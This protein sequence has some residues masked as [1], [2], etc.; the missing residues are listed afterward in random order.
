[1]KKINS[2]LSSLLMLL[3]F[4]NCIPFTGQS[5]T[6]SATSGSINFENSNHLMNGIS[7]SQDVTGFLSV[8]IDRIGGQSEMGSLRMTSSSLRFSPWNFNT[9]AVR[10]WIGAG[11]CYSALTPGIALTSDLADKS[12]KSDLDLNKQTGITIPISAGLDLQ[13]SD[14]FNTSVSVS[15]H[16][17]KPSTFDDPQRA[18][19]AKAAST[20]AIITALQVGLAF[21]IITT[22]M[23]SRTELNYKYAEEMKD[24]INQE[25]PVL[26]VDTKGSVVSEEEWNNIFPALGDPDTYVIDHEV[27]VAQYSKADYKKMIKASEKKIEMYEKDAVESV[28]ASILYHMLHDKK[29]DK[30]SKK[31]DK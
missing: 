30:K 9:S 24:S 20:D 15:T 28:N 6:L 4:I 31:K 1:M 12:S 22:A 25:I 26:F 5:Q 14:R 13:L 3:V 27:I 29:H 18:Y 16:M 10:P 2:T 17:G 7:L 11:V 23:K 8:G 21:K 19:E